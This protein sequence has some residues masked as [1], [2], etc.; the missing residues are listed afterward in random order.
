V[1]DVSDYQTLDSRYNDFLFS[2]I[3][4]Q[5]NGMPITMVSALARLG[6][7]PWEEARR[8]AALPTESAITTV[9]ALMGRV[10]DLPFAASMLPALATRLVP[11]LACSGP[12][13]SERRPVGSLAG[14][15]ILFRVD[16]RWL[17][18]AIVACALVAVSR[19]LSYR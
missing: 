5:E 18:A 12:T 9:T 13:Q 1:S 6:L 2:E 16:R 8:L 7:D 4:E 11:L 14:W 19:I 15:Q 17:L 3:G 10:P